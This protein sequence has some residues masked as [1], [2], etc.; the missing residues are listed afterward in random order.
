MNNFRL[1]K[2]VRPTRY[3]LHFDLDLEH[4]TAAAKGTIGLTLAR[5]AREIKIGRAHV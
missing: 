5:P 2:D 1:A 4:W 3:A